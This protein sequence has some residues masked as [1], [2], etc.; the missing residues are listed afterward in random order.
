M[1]S[2]SPAPP[3]MSAP[4]AR[5]QIVHL[6]APPARRRGFALTPLADVMFQL[7]LFFMLTSALAPYALLPLGGAAAPSAGLDGRQDHPLPDSPAPPA[8]AQAIWHLGQDEIRAGPARIPLSAL[9]QAL[10]GLQA[11]DIED[12][13]VFVT[14][15]ARTADLALLV[16][17]VQGA[18]IARLQLV[19][20]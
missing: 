15:T 12:L 20:D 2:A 14:R 6:P 17:Q 19:G 7:L 5:P 13:V 1:S 8:G 18:G 4:I 11:S 3:L 10:A 9:D 16:E